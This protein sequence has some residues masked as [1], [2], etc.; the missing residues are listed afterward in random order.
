MQPPP[1]QTG[2]ISRAQYRRSAAAMVD[3]DGDRGDL[4]PTAHAPQ[5]PSREP[6]APSTASRNGSPAAAA[7]PEWPFHL[8]YTPPVGVVEAPATLLG[9]DVLAR[10]LQNV[11]AVA[12]L[13]PALREAIAALGGPGAAGRGS[14][15]SAHTPDAALGGS[16]SG[17]PPPAACST[18]ASVVPSLPAD[19]LSGR[20]ATAAEWQA[21]VRTGLRHM[22]PL[23]KSLAELYPGWHGPPCW[24]PREDGQPELVPVHEVQLRPRPCCGFCRRTRVLIITWWVAKQAL[25]VLLCWY[26]QVKNRADRL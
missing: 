6:A 22:D 5:L 10:E 14:T 21:A 16:A 2:Q 18:Q 17:R 4:P 19:V 20:T 13:G 24:I 7:A 8:P 12:G 3:G 23:R 1:G 11:A 26:A 9:P 25:F 15:A